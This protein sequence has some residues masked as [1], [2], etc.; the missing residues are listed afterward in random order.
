[1]V[2]SVAS[3]ARQRRAFLAPLV[4]V[5]TASGTAPVAVWEFFVAVGCVVSFLTTA[6]AN[7]GGAGVILATDAPV[8][9]VAS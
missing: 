4:I 5:V 7:R 6:F 2:L 1:M 8:W 3:V 9:E